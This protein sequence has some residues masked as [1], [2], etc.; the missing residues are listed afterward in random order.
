MESAGSFEIA[1]P[2]R[3]FPAWCLCCDRPLPKVRRGFCTF[4]HRSFNRSDHATFRK[5]PLDE[6]GPNHI[7]MFATLALAAATYV[8]WI[9]LDGWVE[10]AIWQSEQRWPVGWLLLVSLRSGVVTLLTLLALR[11]TRFDR[12]AI[13]WL[14][15]GCLGF[16]LGLPYG[17]V[18]A[19][20]GMLLGMPAAIL[21]RA[22][23]LGIERS[24]YGV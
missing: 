9:V 23:S 4:C 6:R 24:P 21:A 17:S 18:A 7:A 16:V 1:S 10:Q 11:H 8:G 20:C 19:L 14:L 3:L 2:R 12:L 22:T 13:L 15:G 5:E